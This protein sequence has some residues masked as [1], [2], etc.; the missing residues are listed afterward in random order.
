MPSDEEKKDQL[1][2]EE[3]DLR[4]AQAA[5]R[6]LRQRR[7]GLDRKLIVRIA[8]AGLL[9]AAGLYLAPKVVNAFT[10][11]ETDNAHI[12]GTIVPV[13]AQVGGKVVRLLVADNQ[14]VAQGQP[15]L[16]IEPSDY[17]LAMDARRQALE[18]SQAQERRIASARQEALRGVEQAR[19]AL[20]VAA[21][22]TEYSRREV[23]RHRPLV[24]S[25]LVSR[26]Q[27]DRVVTQAEQ[28]GT[29]RQAASAALG[30]AEAGV[31]TL[32]AE[33]TAQGFRTKEAR[34]ALA[35]AELNLSR[36]LVR[37]PLSGTVVKRSVEVGKFV[38][39]GQSLL[40]VVDPQAVWVVANF[41]ETQIKRI[42]VGQPVVVEVDAY[43]GYRI[44]G[45]VD[46]FQAG[47]GSAFSLLPPENATGNFVK[48]VQRLPV[49]ILL[50]DPPDPRRPL[51]P[52][53]SVL[54]SV[55][56]RAKG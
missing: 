20:K 48:I 50:D 5:A 22:E 53:M 37:A 51:W 33:L 9:V 11:E 18:A 12:D 15:L 25:N 34:E 44:Q 49:K 13:S 8:V 1:P 21:Q 56:V 54:P 28:A 14:E 16:E 46:S 19:A 10:H 40:A 23:E 29:R 17:Q 38:Q 7:G 27:Y 24:D 2:L 47:T 43:P 32:E 4:Q 31:Q 35:L 36:T 42:R 45:R 41:K 3:D 52:G 55:D 6:D 26:S 39:V 30:K